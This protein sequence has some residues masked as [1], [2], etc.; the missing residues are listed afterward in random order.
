M[1]IA[2]EQIPLV[3]DD[4]VPFVFHRDP[5][6]R[7]FLDFKGHRLRRGGDRVCVE[8]RVPGGWVNTTLL[9]NGEQVYLFASLGSMIAAYQ[10]ASRLRGIDALSIRERMLAPTLVTV[11]LKGKVDIA[12]AESQT[13]LTVA[14]VGETSVV[15]LGFAGSLEREV[16]QCVAL[17]IYPARVA[18]AIV[19]E[20]AV[21]RGMSATP[22][23][24]TSAGASAEFDEVAEAL[25]D[26]L[27][28][29]TKLVE[30]VKR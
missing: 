27:E 16:E 19:S 14:P 17:S 28:F 21:L 15:V 7:S 22:R 23:A 26:A 30:A 1:M 4:D 13:S 8:R 18:L 29:V 3:I 24:R 10:A 5:D 11:L 20:V 25:T 9:Q 6:R 12:E 2:F